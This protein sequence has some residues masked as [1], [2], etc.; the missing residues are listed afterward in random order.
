MISTLAVL[1]IPGVS[2]MARTVAVVKTAVDTATSDEP[3]KAFGGVIGDIA[4]TVNKVAPPFLKEVTE[5]G[6]MY[7]KSIGFGMMKPS[8]REQI[9][10]TGVK[11]L[12]ELLNNIK[13]ENLPRE[14]ANQVLVAKKT[15]A[16]TLP[17]L[18]E[19]R[20]KGFAEGNATIN[21]AINN[22]DLDAIRR[23]IRRMKGKGWDDMGVSNL[24]LPPTYDIFPK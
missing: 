3:A 8:D 21:K 20:G 5:P 19:L 10:K 7:V 24:P 4:E 9:V 13:V 12:Y 23:E 14:K 16:Q 1:P 6:E 18:R 2:C 15:V 11:H 22:R 17:K